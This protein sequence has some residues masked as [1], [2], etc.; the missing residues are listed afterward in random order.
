MRTKR[1][2]ISTLPPVEVV[3]ECP[4]WRSGPIVRPRS[5]RQRWMG[6]RPEAGGRSM[7][8]ATRSVHG[9][10]M[11]HGLRLVALD[12]DLVV[13]AITALEPAGIVWFRRAA[14][15]LEMPLDHA[16]PPHGVKLSISA[17]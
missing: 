3:L 11:R 2:T 1:V 4:G 6:L 5:F 9:F 15:V 12:T 10:G 13:L 14:F 8:F 17:L 16:S 7:L